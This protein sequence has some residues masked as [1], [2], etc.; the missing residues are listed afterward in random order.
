MNG[1]PDNLGSAI[2]SLH[3][4]RAERLELEKRVKELKADETTQ[5]QLIIA[6]LQQQKL[7]GGR[8]ELATASIN[9]VTV[10]TVENWGM[11][12]EFILDQRCLWLLQRR[13][14]GPAYIEFLEKRDGVPGIVPTTLAKL[15]LRKVGK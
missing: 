6:A 12:E 14:A 13:I 11:V 15:S 3:R 8:G 1:T 7:T 2:D 10:P 4:L 9:S 5:R